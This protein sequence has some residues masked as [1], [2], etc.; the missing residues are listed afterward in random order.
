LPQP[1]RSRRPRDFIEPAEL[2]R[3]LEVAYRKPQSMV[4]GVEL[5]KRSLG[6]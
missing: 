5:A 6:L 4:G 2:V 1:T 3:D